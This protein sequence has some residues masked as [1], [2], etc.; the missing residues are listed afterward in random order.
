MSTPV[1]HVQTVNASSYEECCPYEN[2]NS[3]NAGHWRSDSSKALPAWLNFDLGQNYILDKIR[4]ISTVREMAPKQICVDYFGNDLR[5]IGRDIAKL[6]FNAASPNYTKYQDFEILEED[7]AV[8]YVRIRILSNWGGPSVQLNSVLFFG[9]LSQ[10]GVTA[11]PRAGP[12]DVTHNHTPQNWFVGNRVRYKWEEGQKWYEGRVIHINH[13]PKGQTYLIKDD[14]GWV[15]D[16]IKP[17]HTW[18]PQYVKKPRKLRASCPE[19]SLK[20]ILENL[21]QELDEEKGSDEDS[22]SCNSESI[23]DTESIQRSEKEAKEQDEQDGEENTTAVKRIDQPV[24]YSNAT[25]AKTKIP[26]S[27]V[28]IR[29]ASLEEELSPAHEQND[30][31]S[32]DDD[33]N[34]EPSL[35]AAKA[36][37]AQLPDKPK[38]KSEQSSIND[39]KKRHTD[40]KQSSKHS[41]EKIKSQQKS[42]NVRTNDQSNLTLADMAKRSK[43]NSPE[44]TSPTSQ[45]MKISRVKSKKSLAKTSNK[46]S[47]RP[48]IRLGNTGGGVSSTKKESV[49]IAKHFKLKKLNGI[50]NILQGQRA[51]RPMFKN[52]KGL[53]LWYS[54]LKTWMISQEHLIGTDKS[55]AFVRD[56][57]SH[58]LD[59]CHPWNTFNKITR[60]W[61][62]DPGYITT[63][64][65]KKR[66]VEDDADDNVSLAA[67]QA[68]TNL[69]KAKKEMGND[70]VSW[71]VVLQNFNVKKLNGVYIRRKEDIADRYSFISQTGLVLWWYDRRRFWMVSPKRLVATDK[72]Y[73]CIENDSVHPRDISG[74]WQVWDR[75]AKQFV[76]DENGKILAGVAEKVTLTGFTTPEFNGTFVETKNRH[77]PRPTFM[78]Y[79]RKQDRALVLFYRNSTKQWRVRKEGTKDSIPIASSDESVMLRGNVKKGGLWADGLAKKETSKLLAVAVV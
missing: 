75:N 15:K 29:G 33:Q 54:E 52:L 43:Q 55:Y 32:I 63:S 34:D 16:G 65:D 31:L 68:Q 20:P 27:S 10:K 5:L 62:S 77:G 45:K 74:V 38:Y 58:P 21:K 6:T 59:I 72:S 12:M 17:E 50:Y 3:G 8:K 66:D 79:D 4:I 28:H 14:S 35:K 60:S 25:T 19:I 37:L 56:P 53:V 76:D 49:L 40:S 23:S 39:S 1:N 73:A 44:A 36:K 22:S 11:P 61:V 71:K 30:I 67:L 46:T 42:A 41:A 48:K 69:R 13:T 51:G 47:A 64:Y 57:G 2:L 78:K 7:H 18:K 26:K 70:V 24:K 9:T